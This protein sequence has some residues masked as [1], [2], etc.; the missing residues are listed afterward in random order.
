MRLKL[1]LNILQ[2]EMYD[3]VRFLQ[4]VREH[5][6]V[7]RL[8]GKKPVVWTGKARLIYWLAW[9]LWPV[10]AVVPEWGLVA[11][12]L[13]VLPG[14][15]VWR[16][17][18]KRKTKDKIEAL[19]R[20]G[21]KV[22]GIAGS[23][24]KTSTKEFLYQILKTKYRVLRTP[25]SYNTPLGVTKVVDLELDESYD[26]FICEMGE[27]A[28]GEIKELC[29]MVLPD[30][31]I[32]TGINEQHLERFKSRDEIRETVYELKDWAGKIVEYK[33]GRGSPMEENLRTA[34]EMAEILGVKEKVA[35]KPVEH[36]LKVIE[37]G[38]V[39]VI[40]DAYSSNVDGFAAAVDYLKSFGGWKVIVTPGIAELGKETYGIHKKLGEKL[41]G[42][43][44][45]ILVGKSER[46]KG[47]ENGAGT[48]EYV[49]RVGDAMGKVVNRPAVVL[50]END[51]P[52]NY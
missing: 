11:A 41:A 12:T 7:E 29:E 37:R 18:M 17:W 4:W 5:P 33:K 32:I 26:F 50:F 43:D 30:Y 21:L 19:K 2:L 9:L 14:E 13:V 27:H 10:T 51:L 16:W 31:G 34:R 40:D 36:R 22:I 28:R 23:F 8:E 1:Y 39:T 52:D 44:Q 45:I 25:E 38:E 47:L 24:G 20:E 48:V 49:E 46:T 6:R 15:K 42:I 35:V 3:T